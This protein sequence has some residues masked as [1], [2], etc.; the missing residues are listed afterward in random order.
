M[1]NSLSKILLKIVS[2]ASLA[3][4]VLTACAP[5]T[6]IPLNLPPAPTAIATIKPQ[7]TNREAHVQSVD[8]QIINTDPAQVNA[9][10]HGTL[11]EACASLGESQVRYASNT[12]QITVYANSRADIGCAQVTTPFETTI[13]LGIK[14]L[15]AG[16][17]AV[18]ANGVGAV[19]TLPVES[20]TS[21]STSTLAPQ[22]TAIPNPT[23]SAPVSSTCTDSA[24]FIADVTVPDGSVFGSNTAFT[25]T[26]RIKNTGSCTWNS[27]YL[28]A[29]ISGTPMS[30]QPG[31]WIVPQGQ[32]VAPGRTVD[33]SVGMTSPVENGSYASYW[34][35]K[36]E[37]GQFMPI[38]G[39]ASGNSFYAKIKV[40]DGSG[41]SGNI[42]ASSVN[43]EL[44]QGSSAAC[45]AD[46]T[47][48][49]HASISAD[50]PTAATYQINSTAGQ[51]PAGY[52]QPSPMGPV[53]VEVTGPI[54]FE[55]AST[56]TINFRFVGPYPYPSDI[57]INLRV[58]NGEWQTTK[59]TCQ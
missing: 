10:V 21:T 30:Q 50:G 58:N 49:V 1:K 31:Y 12:F 7:V 11:T 2:V 41:N 8:I 34:G 28:V 25:K 20:P 13:P 47:Y 56:K 18:T 35:L 53:S 29:Y 23:T 46:A 6:P 3:L 38:Q 36:G 39:G 59:L 24:A 43:I 55:Q 45:S 57:T 22:S 27:S 19:F 26:W 42:T 5:A 44:E 37:T 9:V 16:D 32:I 52:F 4:L 51:I 48:F 54:V 15:P 33:I 17:Y 40:D 14:D